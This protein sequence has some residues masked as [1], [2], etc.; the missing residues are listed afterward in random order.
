MEQHA[1]LAW[2]GSSQQVSRQSGFE[3]E[4]VGMGVGDGVGQVQRQCVPPWY[5]SQLAASVMMM[6]ACQL[7]QQPA[8]SPATMGVQQAS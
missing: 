2:F 4:G 6:P 3:G 1:W 8:G 7:V 5:P